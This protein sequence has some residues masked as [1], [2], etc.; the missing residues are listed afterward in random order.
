M[1]APGVLGASV[2]LILSC[3]LATPLAHALG[4]VTR[5]A[6]YHHTTWS[7]QQGAPGDIGTM[8]Q[9][10]D[11]WLWLGT[12]HGLFRFDGANF[13]KFPA[14]SGPPLLSNGIS[15]V[16]AADNGDLWIA[17]LDGGM[18][19]LHEGL[20][21]HIA[22]RGVEARVNAMQSMA[23]DRDG[24]MWVA[25]NSGLRHYSAGAWR[26]IGSASG[27]P[28][29]GA[30]AVF[31]DHDG[32]LWVSN[33]KRIF[34]LDRSAGRFVD[35][36]IDGT[37]NNLAE[38]AD[39]RLWLGEKAAWRV[40]PAP[41]TGLTPVPPG[42]RLHT[43][44]RFGM[45]DRDGNHWQ[46]RC[47]VDVCRSAGA[48]LPDAARFD[49]E[50]AA[51]E[52]LRQE[53][54]IGDRGAQ[55]IFEDREGN[56]WIG[57]QP[58]LARL[59]HKK[60]QAARLPH[61]EAYFQIANDDRGQVWVA[62][63][64]AAMVFRAGAGEP[65][66]VDRTHARLAIGTATDGSLLLADTERI[67]RRQGGRS[68]YIALPAGPDGQP[69]RNNFPQGVCGDAESLWVGISFRG[70]FHR[71][72]GRWVNT[73]DYGIVP[74]GLRAAVPGRAG[75]IWL[76]NKAGG[77]LHVERS[78]RFIR[79]QDAG[80]GPITMLDA[81]DGLIA[82]GERG[83]AFWAGGQFHPFRAADAEVLKS[84]SGI[85]VDAAGDR[86]LNGGKGVV[87]VRAAEWTAARGRPDPLL[88]YELLD[89]SDGYPGVAQTFKLG[90]TA[91]RGNDGRMWFVGSGGMVS[92]AP[93]EVRRNALPPPVV[94]TGLHTD[95]ADYPAAATPDLPAG[96]RSVRIG[97]TAL[98]YVMPERLRF[99]YRLDG[100]D[101]GWVAAGNAREAQYRQLGPGTYRFHVRATN[102]DGVASIADAVSTFSIEPAFVQTPW[103]KL[104]AAGAMGGLLYGA[105][106][107]RLHRM[108]RYYDAQ[109]R[110]RLAERE[111]I[112]RELHDT[113]LQSVQGLVLKVHGASQRLPAQEPVRG[114]LDAALTQA[115]TTIADAR[116]H[117]QDLRTDEACPLV[118]L[119]DAFGHMLAHEHGNAFSLS[120]DGPQRLL[121]P[122]VGAD[123]LAICREALGNA[124]QH[125]KARRVDVAMQ[126]GPSALIIT[127]SDDG[128]GVAPD[129]LRQGGR[130]GHF[131]LP[132]MRER[133][134][135]FGGML[136]IGPRPVGGTQC[137]LT[138]PAAPP[139]RRRWW[140]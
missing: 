110:I 29:P 33:G 105:Y 132:G 115:E 140:R 5:L 18:S 57:T 48:P 28:G 116:R 68:T 6:D 78:G 134:A 136:E 31:I 118:P 90:S 25:T 26:S 8:A 58:G 19:I 113:L 112:A 91:L 88:H 21:R 104:L 47:P 61:G 30:D 11:G 137:V 95:S 119:L 138:V 98:S 62:T 45:F 3:F 50:G 44:R 71:T 23:M 108:A 94:L 67:E 9:T 32:R 37:A 127:V 2:A 22:G 55:T 10:R 135:R 123:V 7:A 46:L 36:G 75:D 17:Y 96:T 125:A 93:G 43:A 13:E 69:S 16:W 86:W 129:T 15:Q 121:A 49:V 100:V 81:T 80:V 122:G 72:G 64:P 56:I 35:S 1:T 101:I 34:Q 84:V 24:S 106:R 109:V 39:G 59:R 139:R 120:V 52:H 102:E 99:D 128:I 66:D 111:R 20:L 126:F 60:F 63:I 89:A 14:G 70:L 12:S 133:A 85:V 54:Q 65:Q 92:I 83:L 41:A 76:G 124:F 131:G 117:V 42:S 73:R 51:S 27:F 103:F 107:W 77:I 114:M 53:W 38:S 79:M 130:S 40:L 74:A 82:G 87:H 97:Y 4:S